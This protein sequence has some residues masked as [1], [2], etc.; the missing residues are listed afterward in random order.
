[1]KTK[2]AHTKYHTATHYGAAVIS[3][4]GIV[5]TVAIDH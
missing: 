4:A 5:A 1:M 2:K 3:A